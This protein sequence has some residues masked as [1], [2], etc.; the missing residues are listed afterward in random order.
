MLNFLY[1]QMDE[2]TGLGG[3][4]NRPRINIPRPLIV[5]AGATTL[6]NVK[7]E[8]SVVGAVNT[9]EVRTIDIAMDQ[10][11][12]GGNQELADALK[13]FTQAV[14]DNTDIA[15]ATKNE[16]IEQIAFVSAQSTKPQEQRKPGMVKAAMASISATVSTIA[17]LASLWDHLYPLI[18]SLG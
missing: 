10:I 5:P 13:T 16:L 8:G 17:N 2:I 14:I 12:Q 9:G 6:H 4:G 18:G 1:D 11:R 7:I 15:E 3:F